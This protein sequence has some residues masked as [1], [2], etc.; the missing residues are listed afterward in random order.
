MLTFLYFAAKQGFQVD[1]YEDHA[2]GTMTK[3]EN[4]V[5]WVSTVTLR[6][7]IVFSGD[8]NANAR[9]RIAT[10]SRRPRKV[11]HRQLGEERDQSRLA[12]KKCHAEQQRRQKSIAVLVS[13][14]RVSA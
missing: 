14:L 5:P 11:L 4:G 3:G 1:S 2:V 8:R 13:R 7:K 10:A 6:P 12:G 9:R